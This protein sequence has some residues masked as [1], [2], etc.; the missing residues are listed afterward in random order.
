MG[1]D[2]ARRGMPGARVHLRTQCLLLGR[3]SEQRSTR[4]RASFCFAGCLEA[5]NASRTRCRLSQKARMGLVSRL[6]A[7]PVQGHGGASTVTP[8]DPERTIRGVST[9][10][11]AAPDAWIGR[12]STSAAA[13]QPALEIDKLVARGCKTLRAIETDSFAHCL[14]HIEA[15]DAAPSA[16]AAVKPAS[17]P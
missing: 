15:V 10:S 6:L 4:C 13:S 14:A 7:R 11:Q 3:V 5:E 2:G 1:C 16:A 17:S 9:A 8:E 12:E